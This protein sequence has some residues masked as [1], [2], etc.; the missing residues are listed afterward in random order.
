VYDGIFPAVP[1]SP[2]YPSGLVG[3]VQKGEPL[4][5]AMTATTLL[6]GSE[7]MGWD[8]APIVMARLGLAK[9]LALNLEQFPE[10]WQFFVNGWG[11]ISSEVK[12]DGDGTS[13]F[14]T[15][16]VNVVG[17]PT[18]EKVPIPAW[19]FRHMSMEAMSVLATAMNEAL[20]QSYDG[21]IRVFPAF[22]GSKTSRFTLHAQCGFVISSEIRAGVVQWISIKSLYGNP[23]K[24]ELPWIKGIAQSSLRSKSRILTGKTVLINTRAEELIT[25]IPEG[26]DLDNWSVAEEKP[27]ANQ[28]I[29]YHISGKAQLGIPRMF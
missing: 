28:N 5:N 10:R 22:K 17:S 29:K 27:A 15:N 9:E 21:T 4:F 1:R 12:E 13:Y 14:K 8:P 7:G 26:S 18:G 11:H 25:L 20:L 23:C 16:L 19:P 3:L 24:I 2:V 6:Y